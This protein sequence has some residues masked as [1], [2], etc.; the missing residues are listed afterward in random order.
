MIA[1]NCDGFVGNRLFDRFHEEAI[2]LLEEGAA[3][4]DVDQALESWGMAIGP[5]RILDMIGNHLPAE[6]RARRRAKKP[7]RPMPKADQ[8]LVEA[9]RI[10]R[11]TDGGWYDYREGEAAP[12]PSP[13]VSDLLTKVA[14]DRGV[15]RRRIGGAEIV[16]RALLA[17]MD[18]AGTLL[19]ERMAAS[20][21]DIDVVYV[22]GYGFP[23]ETG[24]PCHL[25]APCGF[26][27][28][29]GRWS[30]I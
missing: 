16:N 4:A 13:T 18:E 23:P 12:L 11:K 5:F 30:R 6:A 19:E 28:P 20:A 22:N 24:G 1:G 2:L 10:G 27:P 14:E 17:L 8:L 7:S 9:G 3:P 25:A 15:K 26:R 21:G 29:S